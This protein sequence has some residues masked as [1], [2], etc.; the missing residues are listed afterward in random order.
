MKYRKKLEDELNKNA[1]GVVVPFKSNVDTEYQKA[2]QEWDLLYKEFVIATEE[3]HGLAGRV[4]KTRPEMAFKLE[5]ANK[6]MKEWFPAF[7][8][9]RTAFVSFKAR[10]KRDENWEKTE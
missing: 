2:F 5:Y 9:L 1:D 3:L 6:V 4:A 7:K 8:K 10:M